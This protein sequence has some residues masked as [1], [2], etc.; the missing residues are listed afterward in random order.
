MERGKHD[1]PK[2]SL[3]EWDPPSSACIWKVP[4]ERIHMKKTFVYAYEK[5]IL[6]WLRVLE[7]GKI[8]GLADTA[9]NPMRAF[10]CI[11]P[12]WEAEGQEGLGPQALL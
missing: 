5:Q 11:I 2:G 9:L 7:V 6:V 4:V 10:F 12:W 8:K 1:S 3:E